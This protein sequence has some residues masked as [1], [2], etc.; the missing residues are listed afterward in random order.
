MK[1]VIH[2][3]EAPEAIGPYSQAIV[4]GGT[5]YCSGQIG[6]TPA[7]GEMCGSS[8]EEQTSQVMKNLEGV[9]E[10]AGCTF[11]NVVKCTIFLANMEDFG[12]V[13][14]I[15]GDSFKLDPPA[16]ET[17]AVRTLPKNALVEIS[18]IAVR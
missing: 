15:Y 16:R 6:I 5:V 9:L 2:S 18:C 14:R 13:N 1:K 11:A 8:I 3:K 4:T 10:S 7:T 12:T 17:V